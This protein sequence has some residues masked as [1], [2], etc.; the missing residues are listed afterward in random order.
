M[1][2][3]IDTI[4][5][6]YRQM[7]WIITSLQNSKEKKREKCNDFAFYSNGYWSSPRRVLQGFIELSTLRFFWNKG[8]TANYPITNDKN[9]AHGYIFPHQYHTVYDCTEFETSRIVSLLIK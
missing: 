8:I 6:I 2:S 5:S 7:F 9:M 3:V 1:G 4:V